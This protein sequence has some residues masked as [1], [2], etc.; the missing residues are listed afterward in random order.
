ML[1]ISLFKRPHYEL[2]HARFFTRPRSGYVK[3]LNTMLL[4]ESF[5]ALC[6][7][8]I[9][10]ARV[11]PRFLVLPDEINGFQ[12]PAGQQNG[13]VTIPHVP[14]CPL[15]V[16]SRRRCFERILRINRPVFCLPALWTPSA[17]RHVMFK[18]PIQ[19]GPVRARLT[20]RNN[21]DSTAGVMERW[22]VEVLH[23]LY[24]GRSPGYL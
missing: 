18:R 3:H 20:A 15:K 10:R 16:R 8:C 19:C 9:S 14:F 5:E 23:F 21:R 17:T 4:D 7:V 6:D 13:S 22:S 24:N 11:Q 2:P 1:T 12:R